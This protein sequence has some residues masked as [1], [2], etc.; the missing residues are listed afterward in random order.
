MLDR[1]RGVACLRRKGLVTNRLAQSS[2]AYLRQHAHQA[3]DWRIWGPEALAEA[4]ALDRPLF[5]SIGYAACHWCHVMSHESFD[6]AT[7]AQL[8]N[9]AFIPIKIDREQHPDVD[10]VYMAATQ[11]VTGSGGWPMSVFALPDGRPFMAGTYY[12]PEDRGGLPSFRRLL[13]AMDDAWRRQRPLVVD[14]ATA[15]TA[16]VQSEQDV[17]ERLTPTTDDVAGIALAANLRNQ[18]LERVD[19]D[20]GFSGAPKFPRPSFVRAL[21]P[22]VADEQVRMAVED[23]LDAMSRRGLYDH[24]EGGFARY[25]VDAS[26]HV[27]HF[28]KM[29]SDQALLVTVYL[30]ADKALAGDTPYRTVALHTLDF[31]LRHLALDNGFASALDADTI[32]GEGAHVTWTRAEVTET[33]AAAN[34]AHV[35]DEICQRFRLDDAGFEGRAIPRLAGGASFQTPDHLL[36]ALEVLRAERA[37]R[38]QPLRDDKCVTEYNAMLAVAFLATDDERYTAHGEALVDWLWRAHRPAGRTVRTA[39]GLPAVASDVAWLA[40]A[41]L[42]AYSATGND[43]WLDRLVAL[44]DEL[45]TRFGEVDGEGR[46]VGLFASATEVQQTFVRPRDV[47]DGATPSSLAVALEVLT[48]AGHLADHASAQRAAIA[49]RG[50]VANL[51]GNHPFSAPDVTWSAISHDLQRTIVLPGSR[52]A[53]VDALH[54]AFVPLAVVVSGTGR[55]PLLQHRTPG[56]AYRCTQSTCARPD[57]SSAELLAGL[58]GWASWL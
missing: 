1:Q 46:L 50:V 20:G 57:T 54:S 29:L 28:E 13:T 25:S 33:L 9:A 17:L 5:L 32:E 16:A 22:F 14:Q 40:K 58:Q 49:L 19:P 27:P 7:T 45:L 36:P 30:E 31:C 23:A 48:W 24:L 41:C 44:A 15:I 12:P 18:L 53:W 38:P 52:D 39:D 47:F 37:T 26:W 2:S 8:L 42:R 43:V 6:D 56:L 10:S 3:V 35:V 4:V 11:A 34:L 21:L 51:V 55:S